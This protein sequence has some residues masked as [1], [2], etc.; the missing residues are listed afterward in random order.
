MMIVKSKCQDCHDE[1]YDAPVYGTGK[2]AN[3]KGTGKVEGKGIDLTLL[4]LEIYVPEAEVNCPKCGGNG[5]CT[6]CMGEGEW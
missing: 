5:V 3:C 6:T 4:V 1:G 2:C